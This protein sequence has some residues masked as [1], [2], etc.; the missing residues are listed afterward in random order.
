MHVRDPIGRAR[1]RLAGEEGFALIVSLAVTVVLGIGAASV[2][3]SSASGQ[4]AANRSKADQIAFAL[5]E[6]GL[7]DAAAVLSLP[8]NNALDPRTFCSAPTDPL[9]CTQRTDY[10]GGYSVWGGTLDTRVGTWTLQATGYALHPQDGVAAAT[11]ARTV[12]EKLDVRPSYQQPLNNMAW[13]YIWARRAGF[14]CDMTIGQSVNVATPLVVEGNLCLQNTATITSGPLVIKGSF[15]MDQKQNGVGS[16]SAPIGE[17]HIGGG[18]RYWNKAPSTPCKGP[19]DNVYAK[20]LDQVVPPLTAPAADWSA[21]YLN[22]SPGPYY[23]CADVVGTPPVFDTDQYTAPYPDASHRNGSLNATPFDL[24]PST[25]YSCKNAGGEISW[26]PAAKVLTLNGTVYI[27]GS[28]FIQNGAVNLYRGVG[29]LY[30]TGTMLLKNSK[31]CAGRKGSNCDTVSWDP[32]STMLVI[33]ADGN[34]GQVSQGD[35]IQLVSATFQGALY[36]TNAIDNGTTSQVDGPMVGSTVML[37]QSVT[38]TFPSIHIVPTAMP[39][40]PVVYAEP[41]VPYGFSG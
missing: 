21:W 35:S 30:L 31:L 34:G 37:G 22:A 40:N 12:G 6:A 4:R 29:S 13:N 32:N 26:D 17:A 24:T 41:S 8:S 27:D 18:C 23:P 7:A 16:P 36:G 2:L 15:A 3:L 19:A 33:V 14:G 20:V 28:A 38:T 11:V 1:R 25:P 5:G 39:S 10:A 9:P